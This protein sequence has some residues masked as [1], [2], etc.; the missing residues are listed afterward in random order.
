MANASQ[1]DAEGPMLLG[2]S[3]RPQDTDWAAMREAALQVDELG[4]DWLLTSDHLVASDDH[5]PDP[6]GAIFESWQLAAAWAAIT[7][8]VRI[9]VMV[10]G[11]MLRHP[12]LLVKMA[13]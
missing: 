5:E 9:G 3:L 13:I 7:R 1:T 6:D 10:S 12:A 8:Q 2:V 4:F 11:V